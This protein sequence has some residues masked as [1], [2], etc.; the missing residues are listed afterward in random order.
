MKSSKSLK[1]VIALFILSLISAGSYAQTRPWH[2]GIKA[3]ANL[4]NVTGRS[5][6]GKTKAGFSAGAY[7]EIKLSRMFY[8]QP[9]LL[10][11]QASTKTNDVFNQMYG[12]YGAINSDVTLNYI[13]LPVMIAFKPVPELSI[14]LG[15]QYGYL[16][17]QTEGLLQTPPAGKKDAFSKSDAGIVFGGQLNLGKVRFSAKYVINVTDMNGI[18]GSDLW[19]YHGFQ[20]HL[21]YQIW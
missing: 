12:Q 4:F 21:G 11:N 8:L 13:T 18:N 3:G 1:V 15:G 10:F 20:F 6:E 19:R 5:F 14:L 7:G 16:V 9:E 17:N 2:I